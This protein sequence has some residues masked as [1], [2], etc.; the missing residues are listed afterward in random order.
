MMLY[1]GAIRFATQGRDA[2]QADEVEKSFDLLTR[3]QKIMLELINGLREE[4]DPP[5]VR[6]MSSLYMFIYRKL[7]EGN[8]NR[9]VVAID[10]ALKL[11]AH[12][13]ETWVMLLSKLRAEQGGPDGPPDTRL[14]ATPSSVAALEA[15]SD[16]VPGSAGT[17]SSVAP[18][19]AVLSVEG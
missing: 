17:D 4:V 19:H 12:Q 11:L 18:G 1:D 16:L 15:A 2:I 6:R 7:V 3:A 8:V 5:L 13:R 10:E 14:P 9:D